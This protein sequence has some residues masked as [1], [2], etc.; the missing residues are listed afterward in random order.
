MILRI[1]DLG[2]LPISVFEIESKVRSLCE[3]AM[4]FL[5]NQWLADIAEIFLVK[6]HVWSILISEHYNASTA[7]IKKYF[8]SVNS[9]LSKQLRMVVMNTLNH[10]RDFF[11]QYSDGNYYKG[12]YEDLTFFK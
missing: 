3:V 1:E 9:L 4:D 6:K 7:L 12:T 10:M 8:L 11:M 5:I 2:S